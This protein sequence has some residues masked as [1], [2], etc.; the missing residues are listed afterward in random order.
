[1]PFL[2][3][4]VTVRRLLSLPERD[5]NADKTFDAR[6]GTETADVVHPEELGIDD[7][8]AREGAVMYHPAP[9]RV[10]RYMLRSL[11][12]SPRDYTFV[13]I[14][15]GKGRAALVA[16]ELPFKKVIG[17]EISTS[18]WAIAKDNL[19]KYRSHRETGAP[20]EFTC[21]DARTLRLPDGPVVL[22]MCH[23]F[24]TDI[25]RE[26]LGRIEDARRASPRPIAIFYLAPWDPVPQVFAETL[27]DFELAVD[28]RE[29]GDLWNWQLYTG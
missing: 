17:I 23:P 14:G 12:G 24:G 3:L 7:A 19:S 20:V 16:S 18:L 26:V 22:Y 10:T 15:A 4:G 1:M 8:V 28:F 6:Y 2:G 11:P 25:L 5:P 29:I 27:P 9:A 13:D 21:A